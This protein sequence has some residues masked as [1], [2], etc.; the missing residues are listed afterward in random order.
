MLGKGGYGDFD[1]LKEAKW[2]DVQPDFETA[3][4]LKGFG[5]PDGKFRF[6]PQWVGGAAPEQA[7]EEH[8]RRLR[9]L[10]PAARISRP[11]RPDRGRPTRSI[12]SGSRP[13]RRAASSTPASPRPPRRRPRKAAGRNCSSIPTTPRGWASPTAIASRSATCAARW[14]CTRSS[15]TA[16]KRGVVIAEGIWPND[17]HER[18]EGINVLTGADAPA[19]YGGAAVPRQQGVGEGGLAGR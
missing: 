10:R 16:L 14:C 13:R 18:G 9:S 6:R 7:A 3:H 4:F 8:G 1:S 12:R 17:A 2:L 19:P 15:S 11:C 5:H